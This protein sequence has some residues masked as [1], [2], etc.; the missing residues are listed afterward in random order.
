MKYLCW[1]GGGSWGEESARWVDALDEEHAAEALV[2][3]LYEGGYWAG[4][5]PESVEV[6][7]RSPGATARIRV[8]IDF[9]PVFYATRVEES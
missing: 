4:E 8:R 7:V 5:K 2:E 3:S 9:D 6:S 1:L